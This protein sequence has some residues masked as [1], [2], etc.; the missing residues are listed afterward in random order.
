MEF[1]MTSDFR[2]DF[3]A[4][5]TRWTKERFREYIQIISD[6]GMKAIHWIEMGDKDMG[7]WDRGGS[8]DL[9]QRSVEFMEEIPNPLAFLCEE[10]HRL[11]MKV[12]AVHKINDMASFGPG[13][14]YPLGM[15]PSV[16]P[17]IPQIGGSGQ[18]AFRWLRHHPDKRVEIHPSLMEPPGLRKPVRTIRLWHETSQL[19]GIPEIELFVSET[20]RSYVPYE[21]NKEIS[22]SVQSRKP[23][24][25]TPA[26]E[27][28]F[29]EEG[30]CTCIEIS[31]LQISQPFFAICF[32]QEVELVNTLTALMEVEDSAGEPVVFTWGFSPRSDYSKSLGNFT[33]VGIG[34]DAT[35]HIPFEDFPGGYRWQHSAGRYR[36]N[37]SKVPFIGVARGRNQFLSSPVELAYPSV[38]KWLLEMIQYELDAGCDG[39]DIRVECHTENMDFENYGFGKPIIEAFQSRYGV[40]ITQEPFDRAAW[41][42]LR[43]E[44]FDLFL[45]EASDLLLAHGKERWM[46]LTG[47]PLMDGA[48]SEPSL[49]QVHWNWEKWLREGWVDMVNFKRFQGPGIPP[50]H[51][52]K[53]DKFYQKALTCCRN[54]DLPMAFTPDSRNKGMTTEDFVKR[55]LENIHRIFENGF[56]VYNFYEGNT[57]IHLKDNGFEISAEGLWRKIREMNQNDTRV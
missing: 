47:H 20:N 6:L 53:I 26:P 10:G 17:G 48:P 43:G 32:H 2:D 4:N 30:F 35:W 44:Y 13:R 57:Y 25:F 23:P 29:A 46:H 51:Q 31:E 12:Y 21:G 11:G 18:M 8:T 45:K 36:L 1:H 50:D 28:R 49:Y 37:V 41:R 33:E 9:Y 54:L 39:V 38:R 56:T 40:N 14:F 7:K 42:E 16:L 19:E 55:E 22:V 24:V 15:A 27:K 52:K 3:T 5:Q 34:F